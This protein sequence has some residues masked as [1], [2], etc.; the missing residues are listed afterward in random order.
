MYE[1]LLGLKERLQLKLDHHRFEEQCFDINKALREH[2]YFFRVFE[3]KKKFITAIKKG[4]EKQEMKKKMFLAVS[5]K[6]LEALIL[7]ALN[8]TEGNELIFRPLISI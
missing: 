7:L 2:R 3:A 8:T 1:K 4:S 5:W 6:N